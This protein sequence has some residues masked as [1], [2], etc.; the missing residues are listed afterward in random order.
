MNFTIYS[1]PKLDSFDPLT[2]LPWLFFQWEEA[3][4]RRHQEKHPRCNFGES[5]LSLSA[6]LSSIYFVYLHTNP[7]WRLCVAQTPLKILF[8]V[9]QAQ[10]GAR[11]DRLEV[12]HTSP[13]PRHGGKTSSWSS[14]IRHR[15]QTFQVLIMT[16]VQIC[17]TGSQIIWPFILLSRQETRIW[18]FLFPSW[19]TPSLPP[20]GEARSEWEEKSQGMCDQCSGR[21]LELVLVQV[22]RDPLLS[23]VVWNLPS[24]EK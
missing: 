21:V 16:K 9:V 13:V 2:C 12:Q 6:V 11:W 18:T 3:E 23:K 5:H 10:L 7:I 22:W 4:A 1:T 14:A 19:C 8:S 24:I 20:P 17:E 15:D